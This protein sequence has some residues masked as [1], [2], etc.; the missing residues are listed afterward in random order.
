MLDLI[1]FFVFKSVGVLTMEGTTEKDCSPLW[2]L[3]QQIVSDMKVGHMLADFLCTRITG[4]AA[5]I[6]LA[7]CPDNLLVLNR[8]FDAPIITT[9]QLFR[10]NF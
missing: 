1:V 7:N 5:H 3:Y 8:L 4:R 10:T 9:G 2:N 6:S